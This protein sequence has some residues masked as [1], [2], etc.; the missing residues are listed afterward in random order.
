M[1]FNERV[2]IVRVVEE[3]YNPLIGEYESNK[4]ELITLPCFTM[5]L[6]VGLSTKVYGNY[7][8]GRRVLILRNAV[9]PFLFCEYKGQKYKVTADKQDNKVFYMECDFSV[10]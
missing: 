3:E 1:R 10:A 2:T 5:D 8:S 4:A 9:L 6:G 7:K